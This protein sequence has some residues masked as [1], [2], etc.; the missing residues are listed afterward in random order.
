MKHGRRSPPGA[1]RISALPDGVLHRILLRVG[2]VPAAA[3]TSVLSRRWRRVWAGLP[4]LVL[5]DHGQL[6]NLSSFL[7]SVDGAL[8]GCRAT[9]S[10]RVLGVS[11]LNATSRVPAA[12]VARWLR[13]ASRR[14]AGELW[15]CLPWRPASLMNTADDEEDL[16]LPLCETATAI[17]LSIGHGFRQLRL[18]RGGTFAALTSMRI[19]HA[20]IDGRELERVVSS[21]CPRLLELQLMGVSLIA[22]SDISIRSASLKRLSFDVEN[23][24][25]LAI[26]FP[27]IEELSLSKLVTKVSITAVKLEEVVRDHG[28]NEPHGGDLLADAAGRH[29]RQLVIH[30]SPQVAAVLM[31]HFH[32]IDE[33]QLD[34][35]VPPGEGGY[36][37]FLRSTS[38]LALCTVLVVNMRTECHAFAPSVLHL[39]RK[40][41]GVRR[42]VVH[43]PWTE[44]SPCIPGCPC[45]RRGSLKTQNIA[46]ASLEVVEINDFRGAD[47]QVEFVKLLLSCKNDTPARRVV[48]NISCFMCSLSEGTCQKIRHGA[49]PDTDIKFNVRSQG[50]WVPYA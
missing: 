34:L 1:D 28:A 7:R 5:R 14:V 27:L 33:L 35:V 23:T 13:F 3:R 29:L 16:E 9:P 45:V 46:F 15:L 37:S 40:S 48:I 41:P 22:V 20:S 30:G 24:R 26:D 38:K 50:K 8:A 42:L 18:P 10:L 39:L 12:R 2:S 6:R 31:R 19:Q 43:L 32:T 44:D 17:Q 36:K 11:M 21:Q 25:R 47:H 49:H 4:E